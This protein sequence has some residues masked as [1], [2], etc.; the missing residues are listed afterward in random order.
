M[1]ACAVELCPVLPG[2]QWVSVSPLPDEMACHF[3]PHRSPGWM[4]FQPSSST[5][6]W[7]A[8]TCPADGQACAY[9]DIERASKRGF[10]GVHCNTDHRCYHSSNG[11]RRDI[12]YW[13]QFW[14]VASMRQIGSC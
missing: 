4:A 11:T 8:T 12:P 10:S 7:R 1:R 14:S 5:T 6:A 9:D 13:D 2:K 3:T